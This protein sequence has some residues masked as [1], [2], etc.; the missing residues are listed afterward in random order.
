MVSD[1]APELSVVLPA[2]N[3]VSLLGSTVTNLI[4]GLTR[5]GLSFE[6]VVVENGSTDGTLRLARLLAAQL[7]ELRV[8]ALP[9]ANYGAALRAGFAS[10]RGT[11]VVDFD[12]DYY[13][14][15]FLD[16]ALDSLRSGGAALVV[17]S[18]RAPGSRDRRPL[19][20]RLLTLAFTS[21][22]RRILGMEVSDAHGM[23][24]L[25]KEQLA[26]LAE[27]CVTRGSLYDVELVVRAE[28]ARLGVEE[29][30][31]VVAE[32]RPPRSPLWR[33]SLESL[34]GL[35]RLRLVLGPAATDQ[36]R[37]AADRSG[38]GRAGGRGARSPLSRRPATAAGR[39]LDVLRRAAARSRGGGSAA[40]CSGRG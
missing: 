26:T 25:S 2:H 4:T 5:R 13:D 3:E 8:L 24:A 29:V 20:R 19:R 31:A 38:P 6:L 33:R 32:R 15:A 7:P 18:K 17:A 21:A 35:V 28:R 34:A 39:L 11:Y 12:V 36:D 27:S 10:A 14:L 16:R 37:G 30:P 40:G 1:R 23:K 22:S 9:V